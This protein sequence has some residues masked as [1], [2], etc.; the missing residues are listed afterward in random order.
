MQY[1]SLIAHLIDIAWTVMIL[2]W[3]VGMFSAKR[4]ARRVGGSWLLYRFVAL[5][6]VYFVLRY[7]GLSN[8]V[9]TYYIQAPVVQWIG[10]VCVYVGVA[11]A[12]WARF[13]LG[14]N[15]GMP[16]SEKEGAELV[17]TGPYAFIRNP[18]YSGV[19]LAITGSALC[20]GLLWA[21]ILVLYAA[22]L[23]PSVFTEEKIMARLFPETYPAYKA[24]TKRLIPWVW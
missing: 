9:F 2:V 10:L 11:L 5:A 19:L 6:V 24:R 22:Y 21:I 20:L 23:I 18:I 4:T 8:T 7:A 3:I 1:T 12:I 13:Y 16:M 17:T 14:R 15:W